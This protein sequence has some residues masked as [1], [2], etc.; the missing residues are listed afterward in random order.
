MTLSATL[1]CLQRLTRTMLR[2]NAGL[3]LILR[4]SSSESNLVAVLA[5]ALI[6]LKYM[7]EHLVFARELRTIINFRST[8][9]LGVVVGV[10][11]ALV[12][13]RS[14]FIDDVIILLLLR[15][16]ALALVASLQLKLPPLA[17]RSGIFCA[18]LRGC[19]C[20]CGSQ[21]GRAGACP[22]LSTCRSRSASA[23]TG[24]IIFDTLGASSTKSSR[25]VRRRLAAG[26]VG[27]RQR[28]MARAFFYRLI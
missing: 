23:D 4:E 24:Y 21:E 5:I 20:V 6:G 26:F 17:C 2:H 25:G 1:A 12:L 22:I 8:V 14:S 28:A 11:L 15:R 18:L 19:R 10:V 27:W 3:R 7:I 9:N 16:V 13:R